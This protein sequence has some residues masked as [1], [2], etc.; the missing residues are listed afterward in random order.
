MIP[1]VNI[2]DYIKW[3]NE[4]TVGRLFPFNVVHMVTD[5]II[6]SYARL[7]SLHPSWLFYSTLH[8]YC[9]FP[10][11]PLNDE[12]YAPGPLPARDV[13]EAFI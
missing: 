13:I 10:D 5:G 12:G 11:K 4:L 7:I 1:S 8:H 9:K 6:S 2:V 3:V